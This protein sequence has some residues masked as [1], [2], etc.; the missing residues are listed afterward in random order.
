[1]TAVA[2]A[3]IALCGI[4]ARKIFFGCHAD[5]FFRG[6]PVAKRVFTSLV[7]VTFSV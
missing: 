6:V 7:V 5:L 1:M 2:S 3:R 4:R